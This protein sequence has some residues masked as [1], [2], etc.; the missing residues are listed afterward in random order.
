MDAGWTAD[1]GPN[2][3]AS[4]TIKQATT[5]AKPSENANIRRESFSIPEIIDVRPAKQSHLA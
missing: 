4:E 5:N 2:A 3:R 1:R